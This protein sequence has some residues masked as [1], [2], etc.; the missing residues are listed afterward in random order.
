[1]DFTL[2]FTNKLRAAYPLLLIGA[3][4]EWRAARECARIVLNRKLKVWVWTVTKGWA[5]L[6]LDEKGALPEAMMARGEGTTDPDD[7]LDWVAKLRPESNPGACIFLNYHRFWNE[8]K[9]IQKI[10]DLAP[11]CKSLGIPLVFVSSV[12]NIPDELRSDLTMMTFGFPDRDLLK[13]QLAFAVKSAGK[14][15]AD[16]LAAP[17]EDGIIEAAVGMTVEEAQNAFMLSLVEQKLLLPS[18]VSREK[19]NA[20]AKGGFLEFI[21]PPKEGLQIVGGLEILKGWLRDRKGILASKEARDFGVSEPKGV[22]IVGI[23]G[24]GKTL[25]AKA[26]SAEWGLPMLKLDVGRLFGSLV[27]Q[28]EER[29]REAIATAEATAPCVLFIDELEKGFAG[30]ASGGGLDSG[31]GSRVFGTFLSWLQDKTRP[32]FVVATANQV[33]MLPPE[34]LRAGRFDEIFSVD[35]PSPGDREEILNIHLKLRKRDPDKFNLKLLVALTK[36]Y[37]G[38]EIEQV[39]KKALIT[40]FSQKRELTTDDL[41]A[42]ARVTVPLSVTRREDIDRLR[43][44]AKMRAV[45]ASA[46]TDE[47]EEPPVYERRMTNLN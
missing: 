20:I 18:I 8:A 33:W 9:T 45:Q 7:A 28:S 35:L 21:P 1:M 24:T 26:I 46:S 43:E 4:E 14:K 42:A 29:T 19:A 22:L 34:L 41:A 2:E 36:T 17:D 31:V 3:R 12:V 16:V 32:V 6:T 23:P 38:A 13:E 27:G 47:P 37:S 44:W 10:K 5:E 11:L 30:A 40:A 25:V 15:R 39:V